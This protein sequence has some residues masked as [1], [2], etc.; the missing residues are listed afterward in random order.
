MFNWDFFCKMTASTRTITVNKVKNDSLRCS[1]IICPFSLS[2]G[3]ITR[4]RCVILLYDYAQ[5]C[6]KGK[7]D[8]KSLNKK[9]IRAARIVA[10]KARSPW[11]VRANLKSFDNVACAFEFDYCQ[12]QWRPKCRSVATPH[13]YA[14]AS[15]K[16][17]TRLKFSSKHESKYNF[18][19]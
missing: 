1:L 8:G 7:Y 11:R 6:H 4:N 16:Q 10:Q 2:T 13:R 5:L 18:K 3:L 12:S 15:S 19:N 17:N 9:R 14:A